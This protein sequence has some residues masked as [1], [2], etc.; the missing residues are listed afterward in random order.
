MVPVG[1]L[2]ASNVCFAAPTVTIL[3]CRQTDIVVLQ[4]HL[5]FTLPVASHEPIVGGRGGFYYVV[6]LSIECQFFALDV[7]GV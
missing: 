4:M 5:F 3:L 7:F 6:G 2:R 1:S